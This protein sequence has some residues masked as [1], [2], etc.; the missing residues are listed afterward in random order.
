MKLTDL[1]KY[2]KECKKTA[3]YPIISKNFVYP[4]FGLVGE[5]GEVAEKVKKLFRDKKGNIDKSDKL[6][7]AKELGDVMWYVAQI[8][9][10]LGMKLSDVARINLEKLSSRKA[11][12]KVHGSGDNR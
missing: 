8:S 11:R 6:E 9:T 12:N 5:A 4:V 1:D 10:E 7:I 2:Q 3:V